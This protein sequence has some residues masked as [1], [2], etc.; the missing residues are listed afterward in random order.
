MDCFVPAFPEN[1]IPIAFACSDFYVP[2]I[3]AAIRSIIEHASPR[4]NY[5]LIFLCTEI[6]ENNR[7][8]LQSVAYDI[9]NSSIR[10]INV[11]KQ[12]S[13]YRLKVNSHFTVETFYRL[14]LP[15]LLCY[16]DKVIYLDSDL[17]VLR[18][19]A[20]L[21]AIDISDHLLAA[22]IDAD[23]AGEYSG[24]IPGV[25]AY[26]DTVL[27]LENPYSYFQAG[28]LLLNLRAFRESFAPGELL[29][30]AAERAYRYVDQD[31]LNVK[32]AGRISTLDMNWN[33]MTDCGGTRIKDII[34]K[35]PLPICQAYMEARKNPYI[36][37]YA[38]WEKPWNNPQSDFAEVY[39]KY[40]RQTPFYEVNL[41]RMVC[42]SA[43]APAGYQSRGRKLADKLL[44]KGSRRRNLAKKIL[45]KGSRR[46]NF[47]KKIY[48]KIFKR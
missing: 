40:A 23:M 36:I 11:E 48:Y 35:G 32:C 7:C 25:K 9:T 3:A 45:P 20:D 27:K 8:L 47:C 38:G 18:D 30:F 16:Y 44:P 28:V 12:I 24:A 10:F 29:V 41:F 21:F 34:K 14:L 42:Q 6:S 4:H 22:V 31:V 43:V 1:N 13:S 17:I 19:M 39:W 5:D 46:W 26:C 33:V 15:Q 2:Y 37:H